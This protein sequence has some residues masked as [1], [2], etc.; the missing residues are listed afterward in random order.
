MS[1]KHRAFVFDEQ[2]YRRELAPLLVRKDPVA[3]TGFIEAHWARLRD[4]RTGTPLQSNGRVVLE[5]SGPFNEAALA[6]TAF[7]NPGADIGLGSAAQSLR[8]ALI[9]L[10]PEGRVFVQGG[11]LEAVGGYYQ[12]AEYVAESV[13]ILEALREEYPRKLEIIDPVLTMLKTAAAA[14]QGLYILL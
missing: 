1:I 6:L 12:S 3:L 2:G 5:E 9:D 8:F 14:S 4:P 7:Y 11:Q 10:Y 13:A